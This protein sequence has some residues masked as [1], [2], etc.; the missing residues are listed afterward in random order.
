[1]VKERKSS[2][3]SVKSKT[4][5]KSGKQSPSMKQMEA[6]VS[7]LALQNK[8]LS[9]KVQKGL[10][11]SK[12]ARDN[13]GDCTAA[14]LRAIA[15]PWSVKAQGAC[16]PKWPSP[17]S[18]KNSAFARTVITTPGVARNMYF[19][20]MPCM[21]A[22]SPYMIRT[23][24]IH[25]PSIANIP[26]TG[27]APFRGF[28]TENPL[29]Y[30]NLYGAS[31]L[32]FEYLTGLPYSVSDF[33]YINGDDSNVQGRII[34]AGF[35]LQNVSKTLDTGGLY[36]GYVE[37]THHNL[38]N[39]SPALLASQRATMVQRGGIKRFELTAYSV[40]QDEIEYSRDGNVY[41]LSKGNLV[42]SAD[43]TTSTIATTLSYTSATV[44]NALGA[45]PVITFVGLTTAGATLLNTKGS[46]ITLNLGGIV[47]YAV[48]ISCPAQVCTLCRWD[49]G[50]FEFPAHSAV[51]VSSVVFGGP[52]RDSRVVTSVANPLYSGAPMLA[53]LIPAAVSSV[54]ELEYIQH[55]EF[56]GPKTQG[57]VRPNTTDMVGFERVQEVASMVAQNMEPISAK[58]KFAEIGGGPFGRVLG[59]ARNVLSTSSG[60]RAAMSV[61]RAGM[62]AYR[63]GGVANALE[64]DV[65]SSFHA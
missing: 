1:M 62:N 31:W 63:G 30:A 26:D 39:L 59:L 20:V 15:D 38:N 11:V 14:Y 54:F 17:P 45:S 55:N 18:M 6:R 47:Y 23:N 5:K 61:A 29:S 65:I 25:Y 37:P 42:G 56:L 34:S 43:V 41:G 9:S 22:N 50:G 33:Q 32:T 46:C 21:A 27:V 35:S 40:H 13:L 8:K 64:Y 10:S 53:M 52:G 16:I 4:S 51:V 57:M 58:A 19:Y 60:R 12:E 2:N 36:Y 44:T 28:S 24:E 3:K 49:C 7:N 48:C